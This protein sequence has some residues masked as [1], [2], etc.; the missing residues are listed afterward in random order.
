MCLGVEDHLVKVQRLRRCEEQ[1][2]ILE[3]LGKEEALHGI[4]FFL[5]HHALQRGVAFFGTAVLDEIAPH[6]LAHLQICFI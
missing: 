3:G 6:Y 2:E 4:G 5:R 1:I